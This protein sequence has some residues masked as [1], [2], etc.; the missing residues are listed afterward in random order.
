MAQFFGSNGRDDI[1]GTQEDDI[2]RGFGDEDK[3][4]GKD[5]NDFIDGGADDDDLEGDDDNDTI[6]GGSG[7]DKID[8]DDDNDLILGQ[9]GEDDIDGGKDDDTISGGSEDDKIDGDDGNDLIFGDEGDDDLEGKKGDDILV[10]GLGS[11]KL[12]GNSGNDIFV[13]TAIGEGID[14]I[15]DLEA[16]DDSIGLL[17]EVFDPNNT[18]VINFVTSTNVD[19]E[20][21]ATLL[22]DSNFLDSLNIDA[23]FP[24]II[25]FDEDD[26]GNRGTLAYLQGNVTDILARVSVKTGEL[27]AENFEYVTVN[28]PE[29][30]DN[31]TGIDLSTGGA[32]GVESSVL[33]L[34]EFAIEDIEISITALDSIDFNIGNFFVI[35]EQITDIT[36]LQQ[37][38]VNIELSNTVLFLFTTAENTFLASFDSNGVNIIAEYETVSN[39]EAFTIDNLNISTD[40]FIS[41]EDQVSISV[42]I[43]E[44]LGVTLETLTSVVIGVDDVAPVTEELLLFSTEEFDSIEVFAQRL[45]ILVGNNAA[46]AVANIGGQTVL[47]FS[48]GTQEGITI[49]QEFDRILSDIELFSSVNLSLFNEI[50]VTAANNIV[51]ATNN[52]DEFF[53]LETIEGGFTIQDFDDETDIIKLRSEDFG[54]LTNEDLTRALVSVFTT[55]EQVVDANFLVIDQIFASIE[56]VEIRLIELGITDSVLLTYTDESDNTV[57]AFSQDGIV[58]V[59]AT[60]STDEETDVEIDT[61]NIFIIGGNENDDDSDL[62]EINASVL[63]SLGVT[64]ETFT[65]FNVTADFNQQVQES[66]LI[67]ESETFASLEILQQRL[68]VLVGQGPVLLLADIEGTTELVFFNGSEFEV[69]TEI[70]IENISD[71]S[72][73]SLDLFT[74]FDITT[75]QLEIDL[76]ILTELDIALES[77][78][79][80]SI[81]ANF[82]QE[83]QEESLL[84]FESEAFA[85]LEVLQQRLVSL[86]VDRSVLILANIDGRTQL[87]LFDGTEFELV[88]DFEVELDNI[89]DFDVENL[90]FVDFEDFDDGGDLIEI[91]ASVLQSLGVT[92]ETFTSFNVTADFNQQVQESFLI[93]ESET[94]ASLEI[95][96]QRLA[97]LVGQ[98]PVLLLA[99][100]EG[101]TELVFFNGSEFE[102]VTEIEIENLSDFSIESLDLLTPFDITTEQLEIDLEILTELDIELESFTSINIAANFNQEVE[103]SLLIFESEAFASLEVLQQRLVSLVVDR[104]VLILANIDGRTQLVLFDGTELELVEDFEVELDNIGDFDVENLDFVDFDDDNRNDDNDFD[105]DDDQNDDNDDD[106]DQ[107]DDD[108]F[109]DDD[110]DFDDDDDRNDDDDDDDDFDDDDDRN[111]DDDDDRNDDDDFDVTVDRLEISAEILQSLDVTIENF[112]SINVTADL[113]QQV[114]QTFLIFQEESFTSLGILEQ[115]LAELVIDRSALILVN[116]EGSTQLVFFDGTEFE[117]IEDFQVEL[118]NISQFTFENNLQFTNTVNITNQTE[119]TA[120]VGVVDEFVY[121]SLTETGVTI[122]N[123]SEEDVFE[124]DSQIFGGITND[125]LQELTVTQTTTSVG[126]A[127][128]LSFEG[129][130]TQ[131]QLLVRLQTLQVGDIPRLVVYQNEQQQTVVAYWTGTE[132]NILANLQANVNVTSE[133]FFFVNEEIDDGDDGDDSDDGD[134]DTQEVNVV[135]SNSD[136]TIVVNNAT[137]NVIQ[138]NSIEEAG[139]TIVGFSQSDSL[140]FN[141][142]QFGGFSNS[143]FSSTIV[144]ESTTNVDIQNQTLLVVEQQINSIQEVQALLASLQ[145]NNPVFVQY[146]NSVGNTVVVFAESS[147]QVEVVSQ[148]ASQVE[149]TQTNFNFTEVT[150]A[151]AGTQIDANL[152]DTIFFNSLVEASIISNFNIQTDVLQFQRGIFGNFQNGSFTQVTVDESSTSVARNVGLIE[153]T[154]EFTSLTEVETRL[155]QLNVNNSGVFATY[156]NAQNE[157]VLTFFQGGSLE[158]VATFDAEINLD[159]SNFTFV[160]IAGGDTDD[161]IVGTQRQD[162]LNG[163]GGDDTIQ[164]LGGDDTLRGGDDNDSITGNGGSDRLNGGDGE[165]TLNGGLGNDFILGGAD[166]DLLIGRPG[167]DTMLGGAGDDTL[168][169]GIGRDRMN[170]GA[171]NDVLTGGASIDRF[172]FNTNEEF[173][174]ADVGTDEITDFVVGQDIILL[175]RRTF[176]ALTSIQGEGFS[177]ATEFARVTTNAAAATSNAFIVY[178]STNGNLF[179]NANGSAA[180][181]GTGA[182]FA[183]LTNNAQISADDFFLR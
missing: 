11:D 109:D 86:V 46:L 91:N 10:G 35:S 158:I 72:I 151:S 55:A 84:I 20:D 43:F 16:D 144:N 78:T 80:I 156:V 31:D 61:D 93:F 62:I 146:T 56:E 49:I 37:Q 104:S 34:L 68:A 111:D 5:G 100:I 122:T 183:T 96:Q 41:N 166:D 79:S 87:V 127:N 172:I 177:V 147:T 145:V 9:E 30:N 23:N 123:Y 161:I 134:D 22:S 180:G 36:V 95:L 128:L 175:D 50:E 140:S 153:L 165:D 75:E 21:V 154:Q 60:F 64:A 171:G 82:N 7:D 24:T 164:G 162:I 159:V 182:N 119:V 157:T 142:S 103:E 102:V 13:Y 76:E 136:T 53:I 92:A 85:S 17:A 88:E 112:T 117:V 106:D 6:L 48:D 74:P 105:D 116:I 163:F 155:E 152:V 138:I 179:Y 89:G 70:E 167:F 27:S 57:F 135:I 19:N 108:D 141:S 67:F 29:F 33:E 1:K 114:Q 32:I 130:F 129:S 2:I 120:T 4:D 139:A 173:V 160:G 118:E 73:D 54:D 28:S 77:F 52:P 168:S 170:G 81:D 133:N 178:N 148:F 137:Q 125:T 26:N 113:T 150:T 45:S 97:V 94:F 98:R 8:G 174:Q 121:N 25:F 39:L 143:T 83:V 14:E 18:Q 69:V 90:D 107:N 66:F 101:T 71:F 99:D 126:N 169:G 58:E 115:R 110:D 40:D 131:Q 42:S 124:C 15:S 181:L 65:S 59:I 63:Q 149:L 3:L 44:Q 132:I 176:A 12:R 38:L 51:S 47:L